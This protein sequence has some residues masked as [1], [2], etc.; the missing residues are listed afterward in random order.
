MKIR[1]SALIHTRTFLHTR[2]GSETTS[3]LMAKL[4]DAVQEVFASPDLNAFGWYP[5]VVWNSLVEE[6]SRWPGK[7]G[8]NAI[9]DIA[10][11]VA[12]RDL[13]LAHKVLLKLGTPELVLR[14]ASVFWA[15]YF[16]GGN[17]QAFPQGE[18]FFKLVLHLGVDPQTDPGK[19]TCREA[20]TAWQENAIRLAGARGGRSHH[21]K[22]RFEGHPT[23]EFEVR[24][25]R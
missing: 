25:M 16:N 21:V 10:G 4:P 9:R 8:A 5:V 12:E 24:W 2:W 3:H 20:V 23:C 14:Q 11:Y 19:L 15:T 17:L 18:R 6:V 1:G 7:N 22:C 13:T